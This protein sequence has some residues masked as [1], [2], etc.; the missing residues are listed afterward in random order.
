VSKVN[1]GVCARRIFH[2]EPSLQADGGYRALT[3][4]EA[5]SL[6]SMERVVLSARRAAKSPGGALSVALKTQLR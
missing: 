6:H 3:R 1:A 2:G 5:S 4:A